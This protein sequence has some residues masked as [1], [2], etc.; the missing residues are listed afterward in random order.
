MEIML[1]GPL[2]S[3]NTARLFLDFSP[4]I[5][6]FLTEG[7]DKYNR[8][9]LKVYVS[10]ALCTKIASLIMIWFWCFKGRL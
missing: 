4:S 8:I 6:K 3:I 7:K 10:Y 5:K 9:L 2:T 1:L